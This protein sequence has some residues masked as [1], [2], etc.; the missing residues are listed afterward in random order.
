MGI[1]GD[2]YIMVCMKCGQW[3]GDLPWCDFCERTGAISEEEIDAFMLAMPTNW[4]TFNREEYAV[5][6]EAAAKRHPELIMP[7]WQKEK[8]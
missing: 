1:H 4:P 8:E 5:Y 2:D 7:P 3:C 6:R